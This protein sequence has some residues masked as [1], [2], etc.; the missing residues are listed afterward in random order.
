MIVP[1]LPKAARRIQPRKTIACYCKKCR[2][3][4]SA[5]DNRCHALI[6][7]MDPEAC[8]ARKDGIE[9]DG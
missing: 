8:W 5:F 3:Y 2:N 7:V 1:K 9:I 6:R 4:N